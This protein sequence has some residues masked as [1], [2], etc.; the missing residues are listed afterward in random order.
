MRFGKSH[1]GLCDQEIE[2]VVDVLHEAR[3][4]DRSPAQ[5]YAALLDEG[6]YVCS[7]STMYRIL[8]SRSEIAER[9]RI[10]KHPIYE[11]P[12][13]LATGPNQVWSWDITKLKGPV[14]WTY[15]YLYVIIDIYSRNV[16]GWLIA[17]RESA[18][19]AKDLITETCS[20]QGVNHSQLIGIRPS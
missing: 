16:V 15:Y 12:E 8:R 6:K 18:S 10:R 9:R 17:P 7:I 2:K 13:L 3:F 1:R 19:L 4:L 5:I 14:K 11:C 20:R